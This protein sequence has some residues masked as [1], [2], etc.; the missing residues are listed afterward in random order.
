ME[1][2][3]PKALRAYA[4]PTRLALVGLLRRDGPQT[5]TQAA[6]A[7][8]ESVASC[9]FHLRQL[10]KY[11]LIE[12]LEGDHG[13]AKPWRAT[14]QFTSWA[15]D[16]TDPEVAAALA[17]LDAAVL[18]Q[19][20][21]RARAWFARREQEPL[22]WRRAALGND[23]ILHLTAPELKRLGERFDAIVEEFLPRNTD[24][25][26]RPKGSRPV[27]L[28]NLAFPTTPPAGPHDHHSA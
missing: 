7:I 8:G 18:D 12:E 24:P 17:Q 11:G 3:D 15:A 9:S 19:H 1:L 14:A 10:A 13:R 25:T 16:S 28:V 21:D 5:A 27:T 22:A 26:L 4:H 20:R 6:E 2:T 23:W